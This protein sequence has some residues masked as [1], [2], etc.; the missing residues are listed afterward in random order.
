MPEPL[1][2]VQQSEVMEIVAG[3]RRG[4]AAAGQ[5]APGAIPPSFDENP[6][7]EEARGVIIFDTSEL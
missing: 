1:L 7:H 5:A 2:R 4:S 3:Q 6:A